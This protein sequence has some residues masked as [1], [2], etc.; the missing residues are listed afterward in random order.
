MNEPLFGRLIPS[1][2]GELLLLERNQALIALDFVAVATGCDKK[3]SPSACLSW[4][5]EETPVLSEAARQLEAY[6]EGRRRIF[7]LPLQP[8]GTEFRRKTWKALL[9]I[10]FGSTISYSDLAVKVGGK[11]YCRAVG[12]ANHHNPIPII[13]PCHR[14]IGRNGRLV[15]YASGLETKQWLIEHERKHCSD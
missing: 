4:M 12:Q 3:Q 5:A 10:P 9:E 14:V 11:Q 15:G 7:E 13:I 1:P 8:S 6:F 2:L